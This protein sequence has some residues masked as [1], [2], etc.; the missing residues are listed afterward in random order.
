M[1]CRQDLACGPSWPSPVPR[2]KTMQRPEGQASSGPNG[3]T[4]DEASQPSQT[5]TRA[6]RKAYGYNLSFPSPWV[7]DILGKLDLD[8]VFIDGEHGPFGLDQLEDL[9]R[10]AERYNLTTVARVPDI[11]SS[12]IL[13]YLDRGIMGILGPHIAT[14]ADAA[15]LCGLLFRSAQRTTRRHRGTDY[16]AGIQTRRRT[17]AR[18]TNRCWWSPCWRMS[19]YWTI[20]TPFSRCR[21]S[22]CTASAPRLCPKSWLSGRTRPSGSH[23]N[24]AGD[25]A[26]HPP[27]WSHDAGGRDAR[28][29]GQRHAARCG[30]S[31]PAI[32]TGRER[33]SRS[34]TCQGGNAARGF[35]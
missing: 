10:T 2:V 3:R 22:T 17:T 24:D 25:H 20:S 5:A 34:T 23:Q 1:K 6:G 33:E 26:A 32:A 29:M 30:S 8:F 28:G 11:G 7:I 19:P 18:P 16:N 15:Q 21:A 12:T 13:R 4:S 14:A 9:C 31:H 27:G 35:R